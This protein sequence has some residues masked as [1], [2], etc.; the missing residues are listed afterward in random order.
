MHTENNDNWDLTDDETFD[1]VIQA[2]NYLISISYVGL[3]PL[4]YDEYIN[5][6][7]WKL[8]RDLYIEHYEGKCQECYLKKKVLHLHHKHYET[9]LQEEVNDLVLLC[10]GCHKKQHNV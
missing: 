7:I 3:I 1:K 10:S 2:L 4:T 8:R 6:S 9:V 5:H